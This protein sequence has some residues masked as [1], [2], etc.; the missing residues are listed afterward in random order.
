MRKYE[1]GHMLEAIQRHKIS[2]LHIVPSIAVEMTKY[3][4]IKIGKV[5]LTSVTETFSCGAP[6]GP[7]VSLEY[8]SIWPAG[9][10]NVKQ[11]FG[12]TE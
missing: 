6:L 11:A 3:Q 7:A 8:E 12:M 2:E 1:L 4:D 9:V 10:M 5:N